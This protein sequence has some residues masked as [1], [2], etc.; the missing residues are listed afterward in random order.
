MTPE[1]FTELARVLPEAC[2]FINSTGEILAINKSAASLFGLRSKE[3]RGKQLCEFLTNSKE[4]VI[5]YLQACSRSRKMILGSLTICTSDGETILFRSEGAVIQPASAESPAQILLRLEKRE[6]A[7]NN[8]I[9]LNQKIEQL[10][11]EIEHR[12]QAEAKLKQ[13]LNELQVTQMQLIHQEKL[14]G[15]GQI[16]AG[17]A[18]EINNPV[19]FIHG[20]LIPA[21]EYAKDLLR[22]V[23]L[24]QQYYPDP[25]PEIQAEIEEI[26][27]EFLM[28]DLVKLLKSMTVG[29]QRIS[30]V[31]NS[32]RTFSRLDEF[33]TKYVDLHEGLESTLMILQ[34]RLKIKANHS[35]IEVIKNYGKLPEVEC[36]C[37]QI[38]QVFMN[39]LSNAIDA[40]NE[41]SQEKNIQEIPANLP[42]I[43]IQTELLNSDWVTIR[44][45]DNGTG[46]S[47][48]VKSKLFEPF[49]T[50]KE[51][52]KGTG[53]GLSISHN[54]ITE[55]HDGKLFCHSELGQGTEFVIQIPIHLKTV[56]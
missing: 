24:Y 15:L 51:V 14:S 54:I 47:E 26:D 40:L 49:F 37:G 18:H 27:L 23:K 28:E 52:G 13:T 35:T 6:R 9:V 2:I 1:Q 21:Q 36:Y 32:M 38:N 22:L 31:V 11:A 12:R 53:L 48:Q 43:K 3:L 41:K 44:I 33:E 29:T 45:A 4:T 8:F 42:Q 25:V 39:I 56:R 5:K 30:Q 34:H 7:N 50:T 20:N 46:I 55:K 17:V 19:S 10:K 16:A